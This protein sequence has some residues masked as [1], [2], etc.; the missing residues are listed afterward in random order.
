MLIKRFFKKTKFIWWCV[1]EMKEAGKSQRDGS[2]GVYCLGRSPVEKVPVK[3][4]E[5]TGAYRLGVDIR[6]QS[7]GKTPLSGK[8]LLEWGQPL[9]GEA[10]RYKWHLGG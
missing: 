6:G 4:L 8:I 1:L 5:P 2:N 9:L 7:G 10:R 3:E